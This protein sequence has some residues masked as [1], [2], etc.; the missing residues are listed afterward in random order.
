[1]NTIVRGRTC[2][3]VPIREA[4]FSLTLLDDPA[5]LV[6]GAAGQA[7]NVRTGSEVDDPKVLTTGQVARKFRITLQTLHFYEAEGL[8]TPERFEGH[9]RYDGRSVARLAFIM[10]HRRQGLS[11]KKIAQLLASTPMLLA[12]GY[13]V[14]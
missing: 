11:L 7:M 13:A 6:P 1:M 3:S 9:R 8:V 14:H 10:E 5:Q 12:V 2:R 4:R